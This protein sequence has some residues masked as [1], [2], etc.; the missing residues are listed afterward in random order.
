M[1]LVWGRF[2]WW[3]AHD[4]NAAA[5][6]TQAVSAAITAAVT[7]VLCL[8]TYRYMLLTK[9]LAETAS[10]Q[11]RT[12]LRPLI[13]ISIDF[14]RGSSPQGRLY[15]NE[16]IVHVKNAGT[17]PVLVSKAYL[18][19]KHSPEDDDEVETELVDLRNALIGI[20]ETSNGRFNMQA[21]SKGPPVI[22]H[23]DEWSDWVYVSLKCS[24]ID[25]IAKMSYGYQRATGLQVL[26]D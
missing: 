18:R 16:G 5:T 6:L 21:S 3:L 14:D 1:G 9:Q 19:W 7:V 12:S 17:A 10:E 24:D 23:F 8:L 2:V 13:N 15:F 25:R 26:A 22:D 4:S 20:G 11:F